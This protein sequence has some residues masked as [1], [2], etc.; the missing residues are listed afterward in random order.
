MNI[1][2]PKD[3]SHGMMIILETRVDSFESGSPRYDY[4]K[5]LIIMQRCTINYCGCTIILNLPVL[6]IT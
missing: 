5:E 6:D 3:N 4:H 1:L 2:C